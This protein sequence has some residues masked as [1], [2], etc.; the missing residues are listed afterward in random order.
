MSDYGLFVVIPSAAAVCGFAGMAAR[1]AAGSPGRTAVAAATRGERRPIALIVG[2]LGVATGHLVML[3]SP[4]ALV[5]WNQDLRRLI[6]L[7]LLLAVFGLVALL[8]LVA[9]LRRVPGRRGR[10]AFIDTVFLA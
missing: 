6:S 3:A 5:A 7:E 1:I 4:A 8:G 10:H 9:A 2:L